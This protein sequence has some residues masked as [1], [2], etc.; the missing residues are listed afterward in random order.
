MNLDLHLTT[1]CN[2]KCSFCG[3]W[4]YGKAASHISTEEAKEALSQGRRRGY[5][6]TTLTGGEPSLHEDYTEIL[7][8]ATSIGYWTVVTTNG[9]LLSEEM[10]KTLKKC[11]TL[12]RVSI[13]TLDE[14]LHEEITGGDTLGTVKE[15]IRLMAENG[16]RFGFGCTV[17]DGNI[18]EIGALAEYAQKIGAAFIRYT[19]V[20]G[21]RGADGMSTGYEFFKRM[22]KDIA[23]I[24]V[25]NA[26][27]LDYREKGRT[28]TENMVRYMLT[29]RCAG[30]S[31]QHMIYD[32]HGT[33]LPCSFIP[34]SEGLFRTKETGNTTER[35]QLVQEATDAYY[36]RAVEEGLGGECADCSYRNTCK[37]GCMTTKIPEGLTVSDPQPICMLKLIDELCGEYDEREAWILKSYWVDNFTR[38]MGVDDKDKVCMRRLPVWEI[39]FRPGA[40]VGDFVRRGGR[41]S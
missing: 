36:A 16:I 32:C 23:D 26:G 30:G 33:V 11:R 7:E 37:G 18:D 14:G 24:C 3:A 13:H 9:L 40:S 38:R 20:V 2:M 15:N 41:Q 19:P 4:E 25:D 10:M 5:G 1:A 21:I 8:Y 27:L 22:L 28:Y 12:V 34:E 29:R 31:G 6:I 39:N 17:F 35:M